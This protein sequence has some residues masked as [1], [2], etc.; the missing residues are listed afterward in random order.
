MDVF[1][2]PALSNSIALEL[3]LPSDSYILVERLCAVAIMGGAKVR[4]DDDPQ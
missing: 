4:R 1:G 2:F 3:R